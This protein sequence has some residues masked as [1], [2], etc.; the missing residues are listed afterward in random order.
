MAR[1]REFE[2]REVIGWREWVALPEFGVSS[3]KAKVDTGAR[4]SSLH[5]YDVEEFV[6][7][8]KRWVRFTVHP[9]QRDVSE[10]IRVTAP[11]KEHRRVRSSTGHTE[12]RPVVWTTV[13]I[14]GD[15]FEIEITLTNRDVMGFRMLLGRQAIRGRFVVDPGRSF[16]N[17][18]R[19]KGGRKIRKR[20]KDT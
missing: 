2:D 6:R 17:G 7:G 20:K 8:R 18:R 16:L 5:A 4:T 3:I 14:L 1:E 9:E 13:E 19:V 10:T 12:R 11:L 15:R